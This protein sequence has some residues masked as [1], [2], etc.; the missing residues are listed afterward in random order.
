MRMVH[1]FSAAALLLLGG[2]VWTVLSG[3]THDG[4]DAHFTAGL[5][6]SILA[7]AAHTLLILFMIVTGRVLKEA[8]RTRPM[9]PE[10]LDELNRFFARKSA[11][12]LAIFASFAIV[13]AAVL[14]H[15]SRGFGISPA[16]HYTVGAGAVLLNVWALLCEY[17]ALCENQ[18]LLDRAATVLDRIDRERTAQGEPAAQEPPPDPRATARWGLIV[19]ISAWF[20][21]LYWALIVWKGN[22]AQVSLHPWIE[23]SI[24]GFA[25][26]L[27]GRRAHGEAP[28]NPVP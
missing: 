4:S 2:L 15:A 22:F 27:V 25:V 14:G 10:F 6:T 3:L 20:P 5:V 12:P 19:G 26:W 18:T 28:R 17:R 16:W 9:G 7:I 13:G 8:M 1:Y 21:Y 11:Y 23:G 24:L